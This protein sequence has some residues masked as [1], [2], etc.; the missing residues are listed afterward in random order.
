MSAFDPELKAPYTWQWNATLE[1]AL[2][3][4]R[5][6]TIGYVGAAARRLLRPDLHLSPSPNFTT[7]FLYRNG[8]ESDYRALQLQFRQRLTRGLQTLASYTW[9]QAEDTGSADGG[10]RLPIERVSVD[11]DRGPADFDVRHA[12]SAAVTYNI[13]T[14]WS[15]RAAKAILRDWSVDAM[16]R[17]RSATPVNVTITRNIGFGSYA[18]RPDVVPGEPFYIDDPA[19]PGGMRFNRNAFIVPTELR[20]GN[21]PRNALR[22]FAAQQLDLAIRREFGLP[23]GTR[24]QFRAEFFNVFNRPNFS[25]PAGGLAGATFGLSASMLG[26]GLG[27]GGIQGGFNPLYQ[28]GG[29]RS[30]QLALKLLF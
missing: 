5:T 14:P 4:S 6:V 3:S 28:I 22:G 26:R 21:L 27:T 17:A 7:L 1:R 29:P 19:A 10:S 23:A 11:L 13:P 16:F 8:E 20:Q 30:G 12:F 25:D 15:A 18:F 9:S 24:L 2:G